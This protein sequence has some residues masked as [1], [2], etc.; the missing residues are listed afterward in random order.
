MK[1]QLV[2]SH[3]PAGDQPQAIAKV[4]E[5]THGGKRHQVLHGITAS[6]KTR[7]MAGVIQEMQRPTL[8]MSHNKTLAKQLYNEFKRLFPHNAV[9]YFVSDYLYFWPQTYQPPKDRYN[10]KRAALDAVLTHHRNAAAMSALARRDVIAISSVSSIFD[11]GSPLVARDLALT[12]SAGA[13][14]DVVRIVE[15]LGRIAYRSANDTLVPKT[16]RVRGPYVEVFTLYE[17][18]AYRIEVQHGHV[19]AIL[20]IN[21]QSGDTI[22]EHDSITVYPA[23][24]HLLRDGWVEEAMLEIQEELDGRLQQLQSQGK[25]LEA[26]R[27]EAATLHDLDDLRKYGRCSGMEVYCRALNRREP[28]APPDTLIDYFPGNFLTFVDESHVTIPQIGGMHAGSLGRMQDLVDHGF[29]LPSAMDFRPLTFAE[30]EAKVGQVIY[31]S[32]T[33]GPYELQKTGGTVVSQV[34][35][36]TGL[37]DPEIEVV[38]SEGQ[39]EHLLGEIR[40]RVA[41]GERVLVMTLT[42]AS[43]EEVASYLSEQ[44]VRCRW[45]HDGLDTNER[46]EAL[47]ALHDGEFDVLVGINLLREGIDLP[48][49]SLVAILD[50]DKA[51]FLRS[52][53]AIIQIVGRAARNV[54]A[55]ALLYANTVTGAMTRAIVETRRR[56]QQQQEHNQRHGIIPKTIERNVLPVGAAGNDVIG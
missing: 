41:V 44:D 27:L 8:V 51:G 36:P 26:Q 34:I 48:Q 15:R 31:V 7:T 29:R 13:A 23:C 45:L 39:M 30:F 20:A 11:I 10:D 56:R 22:Q 28:G 35:R 33:P 25:L 53:T 32:A 24:L 52:E 1:F 43:A 3:R 38:P 17:D 47:K 50:A 5:G 2:S 16:Y 37:L 55:R 6:G 40:E 14:A 21:P 49:V 54:N 18:H 12:L 9:H 19:Q 42:K 4:V 46:E